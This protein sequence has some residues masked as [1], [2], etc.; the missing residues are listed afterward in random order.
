MVIKRRRSTYGANPWAKRI[1][2]GVSFAKKLGG[3]YLAYRQSQPQQGSSGVGVTKN[4]D[5][6]R[7]Y[8]YKRMPRYKR[9]QWS[10]F[11]KKV[12]AVM[13]KQIATATKIFNDQVETQINAGEQDYVCTWL[14]GKN[15]SL[16]TKE[17][18]TADL[19]A[20]CDIF[21]DDLTSENFKFG[22]S[23]AV[24]DI[25][26]QNSAETGLEV[27][28]YDVVLKNNTRMTD[29]GDA[30]GKAI[31]ETPSVGAVPKITPQTRGMTLFDM[32]QLIKLLGMKIL[33]KTKLSLATNDTATYQ[34][35]NPKN[36]TFNSLDIK[37][38]QGYGSGNLVE[39]YKTR[40]LIIIAKNLPNSGENN[41]ILKVGCTRKYAVKKFESSSFLGV[42]Q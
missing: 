28:V 19:A 15:G 17:C 5:V 32:P 13:D 41:G 9:R 34:I 16:G 42:Y 1:R 8:R 4:Y 27:D 30:A 18:G 37:E 14:Y 24:L 2:T 20:L 36:L 26:L 25:T 10:K 3:A 7:Q 22:V 35:R 40:G 38:Q 12:R 39:P 31:A 33:K 6:S 11:S 23:S 29:F 21:D